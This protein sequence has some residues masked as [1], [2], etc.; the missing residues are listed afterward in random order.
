MDFGSVATYVGI[1]FLAFFGS[2]LFCCMLSCLLSCLGFEE[3]GVA[4][5]SCAAAHQSVIGNVAK[6][7]WF[8]L[9]QSLGATRLLCTW[10]G[11]AAIGV[12]ATIVYLVY[13]NMNKDDFDSAVQWGNETTRA[14]FNNVTNLVNNIDISE[15]ENK[16][17]QFFNGTYQYIINI[18]G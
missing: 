7:T 12:I 5:G 16:I 17:K 13:S 18:F 3:A 6:G 9:A 8:A 11:L 2:M 10:A 15:E 14:M 4:A 1:A